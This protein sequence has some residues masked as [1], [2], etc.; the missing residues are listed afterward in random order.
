MRNFNQSGKS[1][2]GLLALLVALGTGV[3]SYMQYRAAE[4]AIS[5]SHDDSVTTMK[6]SYRPYVGVQG[7]LAVGKV[8]ARKAA[9]VTLHFSASGA[10]PALAAVVQRRCVNA[11]TAQLHEGGVNVIVPP[12]DLWDELIPA[13]SNSVLLPGTSIDI[14]CVAYLDSVPRKPFI[15]A[16]GNVTYKD[17]FGKVHKTTFCFEGSILAIPVS[18]TMLPCS[19]GNEME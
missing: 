14:Q 17:V 11:D 16:V 15:F 10:S 8:A 1:E 2:I 6:L 3:V 19:T 13:V 7:S 9:T 5:V 12:P 18:S 4:Q